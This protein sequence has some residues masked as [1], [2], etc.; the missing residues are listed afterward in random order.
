MVQMQALLFTF[1]SVKVAVSTG[2]ETG[3]SLC[4]R[5][6]LELILEGSRVAR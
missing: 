3:V 6:T 1:F 4:A 5:H 2:V